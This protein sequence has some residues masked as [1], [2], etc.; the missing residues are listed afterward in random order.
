MGKKAIDV[1]T[2]EIVTVFCFEFLTVEGWH[3]TEWAP[4]Q[5]LAARYARGLD[6]NPYR[7]I[8]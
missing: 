3:I 7:V 4:N 2:N 8:D 5:C 1:T 6:S